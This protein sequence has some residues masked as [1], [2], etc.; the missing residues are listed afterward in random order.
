MR[1]P[2]RPSAGSAGT[3]V[4]G[5]VRTELEIKEPGRSCLVVCFPKTPTSRS[6]QPLCM[7]ATPPGVGSD[8]PL[9]CK[10]DSGSGRPL[11]R[12]KVH[13][14]HPLHNRAESDVEITETPSAVGAAHRAKAPRG[15]AAASGCPRR[16]NRA[17]TGPP[18]RSPSPSPAGAVQP[19]PLRVAP[20]QR[21]AHSDPEPLSSSA[22]GSEL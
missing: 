4:S 20:D 7:L 12:P 10:E 19:G 17:R 2:G 15:R 22:S 5:A 8:C 1:W 13:R 18:T 14:G 3:H 9:A 21:R 6:R 16:H 11:R